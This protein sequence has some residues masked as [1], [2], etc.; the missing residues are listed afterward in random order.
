MERYFFKSLTLTLFLFSPMVQA[1]DA[2]KETKSVPVDISHLMKK[3]E[4]FKDDSA[5]ITFT[6]D[7]KD[8][9]GIAIK[10]G[11]VGFED[12]MRNAAKKAAEGATA[13]E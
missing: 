13:G 8:S 5:G 7:C 6:M 1:D 3:P 11:E 9:A 12:C 4:P 10:K 2:K